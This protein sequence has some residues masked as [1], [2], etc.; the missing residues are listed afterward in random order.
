MG[1]PYQSLVECAHFRGARARLFAISARFW[2][3]FLL[4]TSA[5]T[6]QPL[7]LR[8]MPL[9]LKNLSAEVEH[10]QSNILGYLFFVGGRRPFRSIIP[11]N[12]ATRRSSVLCCFTEV[13]YRTTCRLSAVVIL[14][15]SV[16]AFGE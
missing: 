3:F 8:R 11:T 13:R 15:N 14:R 1:T 4:Y 7:I 12:L 9:A 6:R 10:R 5:Q 16:C 2:L